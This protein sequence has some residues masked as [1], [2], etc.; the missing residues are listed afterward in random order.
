MINNKIQ[1][2]QKIILSK[3]FSKYRIFLSRIENKE[4]NV[5]DWL[6]VI[7]IVNGFIDLKDEGRMVSLNKGDLYIINRNHAHMVYEKGDSE[8]TVLIL[9]IRCE[10]IEQVLGLGGATKFSNSMC[11]HIE[12]MLIGL[13]GDLFVMNF[14]VGLNNPN[15]DSKI[16]QV[17]DLLVVDESKDMGPSV[18][19]I[20]KIVLDIAKQVSRDYVEITQNNITLE[21]MADRNNIS[22]YYLSRS[23]KENIGENYTDFLLKIRLNKAVDLLVNTNKKITEISHESGFTNIKSFNNSFKKAFDKSP[24]AFRKQFRDINKTIM[25]S[26]LFLDD[27]TQEFIDS[28]CLREKSTDIISKNMSYNLDFDGKPLYKRPNWR[29]ATDINSITDIMKGID[30]FEEIVKELDLSYIII[31][32]KTI[33]RK[34]YFLYNDKE[35]VF[36]SEAEVNEIINVLNRNKIKPIIFINSDEDTPVEEFSKLMLE[37]IDFISSIIGLHGLRDYVFGIRIDDFLQKIKQGEEDK[38]RDYIQMFTTA[39]N[40]KYES[41][42]CSWGLYCDN[43]VNNRDVMEINRFL[44]TIDCPDIILADCVYHHDKSSYKYAI[45]NQLE[46]IGNLSKGIKKHKEDGK[47]LVKYTYHGEELEL[48]GNIALYYVNLF[49]IPL[50]LKLK[51]HNHIIVS[52]NIHIDDNHVGIDKNLYNRYLYN[53]LGIK[54]PMYYLSGFIKS[55]NEQVV[56]EEDGII[57][58]KGYGTMTILIYD[59]YKEYYD[60][61]S[62]MLTNK[63]KINHI[64]Y[65]FNIDCTDGTYKLIEYRISLQ[66]KLFSGSKIDSRLKNSITTEEKYFLE[67]KSVPDIKIDFVEVEDKKMKYKIER[68][69]LDICMIKINK[70]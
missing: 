3:R 67:K 11:G 1:N 5:H 24:S 30:N 6:E 10:Y 35:L 2:N 12:N 32:V 15:A 51:E 26:E 31:N 54:L 55:L 66:D 65:D 60:Y 4:F 59:N 25:E 50:S 8:N 34:T 17:L 9:Q 33:N 41:D 7:Y 13:M 40:K 39:L 43:I 49:L 46:L 19:G 48:K 42:V 20:D 37:K 58:T 28:V 36:F 29:M 68:D 21:D 47:L 53:D 23:F 61:Y 16:R 69:I 64:G 38:L 27:Q 45:N 70:I 22:Y 18:I 62:N 57:V 44:D 14:S 56:Y 63:E 52:T